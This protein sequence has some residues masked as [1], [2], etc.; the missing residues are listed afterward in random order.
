M[1]PYQNEDIALVFLC[2]L[3][4]L[5]FICF[6]CFTTVLMIWL[7]GSQS[8]LQNPG[9]ITP[10]KE[11]LKCLCGFPSKVQAALSFPSPKSTCKAEVD[12]P[13]VLASQAVA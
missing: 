6:H 3:Q 8:V 13:G 12:G 4:C 10:K 5:L 2:H 1:F 11:L 9:E 7:A